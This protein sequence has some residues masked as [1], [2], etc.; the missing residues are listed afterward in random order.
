MPEPTPPTGSLPRIRGTQIGL[1]D[2]A[3]VDQL[4]T[5]MMA[6]H[7]A[8]QEL[9]GR[10]Y[11][12]RDRRGTYYVKVGHHRMAAAMELFQESGNPNFVLELLR[13]GN[14]DPVDRRPVDARPLPARNRWGA[15][16]NWLGF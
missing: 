6:G 8:H 1:R 15:Y 16:R 4:K 14:W 9:R 10:I 12:V 5:D 7:F 3:L 13:W 11:G 2:P